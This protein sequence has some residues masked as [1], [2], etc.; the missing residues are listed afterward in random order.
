MEKKIGPHTTLS[1][2]QN[3]A[4][5]ST[6]ATPSRPAY[7]KRSGV[8]GPTLVFP[9]P[10]GIGLIRPLSQLPSRMDGPLLNRMPPPRPSPAPAILCTP[11]ST[12]VTKTPPPELESMYLVTLLQNENRVKIFLSP[13]K[14]SSHTSLKS[15]A[16]IEI[17]EERGLYNK[18]M[19]ASVHKG[20]TQG[21]YDKLVVGGS[22]FS[23]TH[24]VS[25]KKTTFIVKYVTMTNQS[26]PG[27]VGVV[28][29]PFP[30]PISQQ[31][32][33]P[34]GRGRPPNPLKLS[35]TLSRPAG[36]P[37]PK[38]V[39]VIDIDSD[40]E[41][42]QEAEEEEEDDEIIDNDKLFILKKTISVSSSDKSKFK[43]PSTKILSQSQTP[44]KT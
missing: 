36:T 10:T 1:I 37:K 29:P 28:R 13:G 20:L 39:E 14:E 18:K 11:S 30:I 31:V 6:C 43:P 7:A 22:P 8:G 16:I 5:G 41:D 3:T 42:E 19:N 34:R 2:V 15:K 44:L 38:T 25:R 35:T 17:L 4:G 33:P 24:P 27:G 23:W 12:P 32:Q 26:R 21:V 40:E 9:R